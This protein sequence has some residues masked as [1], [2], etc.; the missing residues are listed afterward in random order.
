MG[1][2]KRERGRPEL[3]RERRRRGLSQEA[4][5][6][7]V[8]VSPTTWARWER[9]E[10]GLRARH[11]AR[12][13][14]VFRVEPAEVERWVDGWTFP[15]TPSWP[16]VDCGGGSPAA[17]VKSA[18]LLWRYEMDPSRRHLLATLPFVPAALGEWLTSWTYD[19]PAASTAQGGS[20]RA[21]GLADVR[22]INEARQAFGQ[23]DHQ[24]GAGLVRPVVLRYLKTNVTPLLHGR[25]DDQVGAE[26]MSA[27]AGMS[28]MAGWTAFDLNQHGAA[29]QHFGQVLKFAKA[30][31]DSLTGVWAL[32]ALTLQAI[33]LDQPTWGLWLA[34]GATATA[35][36]ADAPPRVMALLLVREAWATAQQ[37]HPAESRDRHAAHQIE[38]L[39]GEAETAY[40]QGVTDADPAWVGR[41][42]E[43]QLAAESGNCWRL[44]GKYE[45]ALEH[46]EAAVAAF[47]DRGLSRSAQ[48]N[49]TLAANSYLKLG[50]VEQALEVAR[51]AI[52]AAKA[53]AS[54][55]TVDFVKKFDENLTPYAGTVAVREFREHLRAELVA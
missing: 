22:R 36:R 54:P 16:P 24:F 34:R 8:G 25:Y 40:Q 37:A 2:P 5:A 1:V 45:R 27:A 7:A 44:L 35:R 41:Y 52:P 50:E 15:E 6:E 49:R 12:L 9:G 31:N 30:G 19:A 10:Q 14:A 18:E 38:R 39:L 11:R 46:A 23:L 20:G 55:R 47:Q 32:A 21:V 51:P 48:I 28:W 13:A 53:L 43:V 33:H 26:L 17:T 3:V 42:D 4:A 29:Q